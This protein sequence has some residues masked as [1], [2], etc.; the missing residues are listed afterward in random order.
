[1]NNGIVLAVVGVLVYLVYIFKGKADRANTS[2]LAS[3]TK[4]KDSILGAQQNE[5]ANRISELDTDIA[6]I[7][8][9]I[10]DRETK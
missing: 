8:G 4:G 3:E 5:L 10:K 9:R 1:M 7:E 2:A 6:A